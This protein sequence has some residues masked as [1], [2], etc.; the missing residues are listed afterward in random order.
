MGD[1]PGADS[2]PQGRARAEGPGG[3]ERPTTGAVE[4]VDFELSP[5]A[6]ATVRRL[7]WRATF[8]LIGA[9][10]G[11]LIIIR[12][13]GRLGNFLS[14]L[15]ISLFLSFAIEPA[16]NWLAKHGWKRGLATGA[17]FAGI[18]AS[19]LLLT[20]LIV[21]A[22]VSGI[23]G[24]I[25]AFPDWLDRVSRFAKDC[26]N[27]DLSQERLLDAVKQAGTH[28]AGYAANLAENL[29][30]IGAS[31]L[32]FI[33]R[34]A[35]IGLFTFYM[36]AE[37][38]QFRRAILRFMRPE[39]Q[40]MVLFIWTTAIA[41]TGAYFYSRLLLA[42][43]NGT[44]MYITLRLLGVPFAAPLAVFEGVVSEFIPTVG[45]YI[46]GAAP[47][48]VALFSNP[49]DAIGVVAYILVYQQVENY[50]L[51]PKL[52]AKTMNLHPAIAFG[53]AFVGGAL[54]GILMAFLA[55][56]AAAVIQA[57]I[58]AYVERYQVIDSELT[59]DPEA[60]PPRA[61]GRLRLRGPRRAR[62]DPEGSADVGTEGAPSG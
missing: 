35:T 11:T 26:C 13:V 24:I 61:K 20:A 23:R 19:I 52:T 54:G 45:T 9:A 60:G 32:G 48:L 49:P 2:G 1:Q 62:S 31:F 44:G 57:A 18:V 28:V 12:L 47:V 58:G 39:R 10:I 8:V 15:A 46:A 38:T 50:W 56:P 30:G 37:A 6:Q 34:W 55:L 22:V 25:A 21:P 41:K 40:E 53:A 7:S 14:I 29:L 4:Q 3:P 36:V 17:I 27:V 51:S 42:V 43:V 59:A 16:V 33:F 5:Q